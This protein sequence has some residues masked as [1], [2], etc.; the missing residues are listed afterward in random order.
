MNSIEQLSINTLRALSVDQVQAAN[1][2]HPGLPLGSAPIVYALWAHH[3]KHNPKNP[4]WDNRDRFVLSAGHGSALL[5]SLL[6]LFEYGLQI[7]D[8]KQFR[9]WGSKTP[10]HPE[11][12]HTV[13]V[14]TTTGPLGAGLA[15][16]VGMAMA[17]AHLSARFNRPEF[18]I[19]DHYTF[20]LVGD[21]CLQ[22]GVSAEASSL[23]GTLGLNKLIVLYDSNNITIEGNTSLSFREHVR[24][25]Y[26]SYGFDTFF[27]GDG[28]DL[29]DLNNTIELAKRSERPA[30]IEIKTK[31]GYGSVKEGS[32]GAHGEPLGAENVVKLK[33]F[34]D[35]PSLDPFYVD[36]KVTEHQAALVQSLGF[37]EAKWNTLK[38]SYAQA[39]PELAQ[40]YDAY[41]S[42]VDTK[43]LMDD[44][45]F[46]AF[47]KKASA[48]RSD[49]GVILNRLSERFPNL[50]GG[51]ADLA[52]SNKTNLKD[53]GSFSKED[54][55]GQNIHFGIREN[56]MAAIGNGLYL[57]GGVIPFVATFFVFTDYL[58]G[59][60]RL[61][62]IIGVGLIYVM[63]H[64]SIG[65]G[66]DGPTH[67]PIEQLSMV[68]ATPNVIVYRPADA[69]ET[70]AGYVS[71]LAHTKT[72]TV[73]A[74]SRQNL[75]VIPSRREGALKG[76]YVL[77]DSKNSTP[78]AI[79]IAT[80]SEVGLAYQA[81]QAL[82][83]KGIDA[84][85]V[86]MPS[87]E[88]FLAQDSAYQEEVLPQA[89]SARLAIEA[90]ATQSWYRFVGLSGK[91][92]GIDHFGASAPAATIFKEFG[93]TV[94]HVSE[95]VEGL[96]K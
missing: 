94:E 35:Y 25:R 27:V 26:E 24:E 81:G 75:D 67:E 60:L 8:L 96:I 80:G 71:A 17:E 50:F 18:A 23:A 42:T 87:Q 15:T 51:S 12:G 11:Y 88:L 84:R 38:A 22:E 73:L 46:W 7:D 32:A 63:T 69:T 54:Y 34:L 53:K 59:M 79:L 6:Y 95:L 65:V 70:A 82:Q 31:I 77:L 89:V 10:G 39:Y 64:D 5:Y 92:L 21:G 28:N 13:G 85:V 91:V 56:A 14:E 44:E 36:P 1:S 30:F 52:P 40:S 2:G 49:S 9:Q 62:S 41:Y 3:M 86:S 20:V 83:A 78:Q 58:K 90:G 29:A 43:T 19:V 74:L 47:E 45:A 93:F 61:S 33:E 16:A 37:E 72:P 57:H 48:T 68:R 76:G 66:E 55:S 4:K